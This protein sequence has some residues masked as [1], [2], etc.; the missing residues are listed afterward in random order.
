MRLFTPNRLT[1]QLTGMVALLALLPAVTLALTSNPLLAGG[2]WGSG[3][4]LTALWISRT[5]AEKKEIESALRESERRLRDIVTNAHELIYSL[6]RQG[7]VRFIAP[8]VQG[9]LGYEAAQLL[10]RPFA[11][12]V[13]LA[14]VNA[15]QAALHTVLT[16]RAA[17]RGLE[18]RLR[19]ANGQEKWF[20]GSI[21]PV[22]DEQGQVTSL[23]GIDF[24]ITELRRISHQLQENETRLRTILD[25]T[26]DIILTLRREGI[27]LFVTQSIFRQLAY[28]PDQLTG[29]HISFLL[30]PEDRETFLTALDETTRTGRSLIDRESRFLA[31]Q[32]TIHW[33]RY[34]IIPVADEGTQAPG[35]VLSA[36]DVTHQKQQE[37]Q[38]RASE[39]K[40]RTLFEATG[41]GVLLLGP[42]GLMDCNEKAVELFG[43]RNRA[44]LLQRPLQTFW[45]ET[46]P[47]GEASRTLA[48]A[49]HNQA[50]ADGSVSYEWTYLLADG[51]G[52]LPA[53]V[54]LNALALEGQPALQIVV[55]DI[56]TRKAM[57][58]QLRAAK[59]AAEAAS[60]AK[61][62]F[63][64]NMS[65]EIRTPMNAI[66]GL[67]HLCLQT[68]LTTRQQDYMRK[69]HNSATSLL[70]IINDILD[71]SK[72]EAG[73]LDMESIDFTLEEVLGNLAAIVSLKAQEKR[74]ECIVETAV[75]IPPSL[76]GDPLRLGQ[77]L[78]NLT[79]NALKFTEQGE[80]AIITQIVEKNTHSV[81]LQFTVRDTG[82]GMTLAQQ[83]GLF[84]AF[85]QADSSITRK[86]GGTGL[87][88]AI[89]K[90]LIEMMGGTIRVESTPDVGSR[91]M[92]DVCLGISNHQ[93][94]KGLI[95]SPDLRGM[96]VLVADDNE[97]ARHVIADYLTSFTFRVTRV[98]NGKEAII[99]VQEADITEDPFDLVVMDYMMPEMDGITA[100]AQI[101]HALHLTHPPVVIMATAYGE[102]PVVKRAIEE[103]D[104]GGFLVKPI[105]QSL[106]F[107]TILEA[108][109]QAR[110]QRTPAGGIP[111][112]S[113]RDYATALAGAR[114]LLVEDNELN[115]QVAREL[116]EEVHITV[117]L[118]ENGK[119][120]V[121]LVAS[122]TLDGV[123]MDLHMPVMD[124]LTAAR[125]I[126][127]EACFANLP[128]LAMT[129]NAMSG[130]R[131][132][133]LAAGMQDHIA[134]P[135]DPGKLFATLA[136]WIRPV[137]PPRPPEP[138]PQESAASTPQEIPPPSQPTV[139][140]LPAIPGIHTETGLKY[141]NGNLPGYWSLLAKFRVNQCGATAAM[142]AA[143]EA[144]DLLTA[145]RLA[146]TLKGVAATIG[147]DTL[148]QVATALESALKDQADAAQIT[149]RLQETTE[150]LTGICTALDHALSQQ[151]LS[152]LL[153]TLTTETAEST[154]RRDALLRQAFQQL[155]LF[156]AAVDETLM[157]LRT[158]HLTQAMLRWMTQLEC[159]V[160]QY[161]FE[162]AVQTLKQCADDLAVDLEQEP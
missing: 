91:F 110:P 63:L 28:S 145:E 69:V 87:G 36:T 95:P 67:S 51:Q 116:L 47:N 124:G 133:C 27:I 13:D 90:R 19:T 111:H 123:L 122:E 97:S 18:Y 115:Q 147:A 9:L 29:R 155:T 159:Q 135:I 129:A 21:S 59:E 66:I 37:N 7:I 88:L 50:F 79:N 32:G 126:R 153:P 16:S 150:Q 112:P 53:E 98:Q 148:C 117:L 14:D 31:Q 12:L 121:D 141:L 11:H 139:I 42:N 65:H 44:D 125:E 136:H 152:P 120:A 156:D 8:T 73:R 149:L 138:V 127:K 54:L 128:I 108:F 103:A 26:H 161:D 140:P 109:G 107:E 55:R 81:R 134:K 2:V 113:S 146:H 77:I 85:T 46:Q 105:H 144:Q 104:I 68:P 118:A 22:L 92:F 131:E 30:H 1:M 49:W 48:S 143:L 75:N 151:T 102:A 93:V 76:V 74:L 17:V 24:D 62:E 38:V 58:A 43:C 4:L 35:L 94:E 114:I 160:S 84:Q 33:L 56:A 5:I 86:F 57:E 41:E 99:A 39:E 106:L 23:V 119:Q 78:L 100:A 64:A 154:R 157:T 101:R 61:G 162:A 132:M 3:L 130:D 137:V 83:A 96:K 45:P 89:S 52:T 10:D 72:I 40:F 82:I 25:N 15:H 20:R 6:D 70:R 80:I 142:R 60:Q 71:F 158:D 34:S